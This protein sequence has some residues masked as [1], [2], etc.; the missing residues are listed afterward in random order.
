MCRWSEHV[1]AVFKCEHV[2]VS[3]RLN[4]VLC[5]VVMS[6]FQCI[7]VYCFI[8]FQIDL[9]LHARMR[10]NCARLSYCL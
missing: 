7:G 2:T 4:E 8:A 6:R 1:L 10:K 3:G 9:L 5:C